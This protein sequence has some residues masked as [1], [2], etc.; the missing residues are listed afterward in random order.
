MYN[1]DDHDTLVYH[2]QQCSITS[3]GTLQ[4]RVN[5]QHVQT[6]IPLESKDTIATFWRIAPDSNFL[7]VAWTIQ[8]AMNGAALL[9][10]YLTEA[11]EKPAECDDR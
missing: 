6:Q 2:T 4:Y 8:N 7:E 9:N 5:H 1:I 10:L 3:I 11:M